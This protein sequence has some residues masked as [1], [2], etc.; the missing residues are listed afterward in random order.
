MFRR[1]LILMT[2]WATS[3]VQQRQCA[4]FIAGSNLSIDDLFTHRWRLDQAADAYREFHK[5][6]A[7][8]GG[9][10]FPVPTSDRHGRG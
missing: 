4:E 2:A 5:Q 7:G 9:S 3:I 1:Q 10:S 6:T 8:K